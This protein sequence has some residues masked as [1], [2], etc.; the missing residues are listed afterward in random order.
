MTQSQ[1]IQTTAAPVLESVLASFEAAK[2]ALVQ[3]RAEAKAAEA[4]KVEGRKA[5]R[6]LMKELG[7]TTEMLVAPVA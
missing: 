2:A 3:A 1:S 7:I 6:A 4:R 5:V